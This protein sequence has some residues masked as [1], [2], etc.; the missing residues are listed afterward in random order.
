[1]RGEN[2]ATEKS[3]MAAMLTPRSPRMQYGLDL[4][5]ALLQ[6]I[7]DLA[8]SNQSKFVI[9]QVDDHYFKSNEEQVYVLNGKYFR[10]AK[11]QFDENWRYVHDGFDATIISVTVDDWRVGPDDAHYNERATDQIMGDLARFLG[12]RLPSACGR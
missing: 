10:V 2:L 9:F 12:N 1:M 3:H 4:T 7:Q 5:R 6:R 8:A 11:Q